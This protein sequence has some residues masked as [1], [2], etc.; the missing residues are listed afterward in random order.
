MRSE[1]DIRLRI[2]LLEGQASSIAK[3]LA[4]AMQEHNEEA[5]KNYSEKLA[6]RKG[7]VEELLWVLEVKM[8]QGVLD[9]KAAVPGMQE[10]VAVR[11]I[12]DL[13]KE[14]R[15]K[16]DDLAL[17]VQALVRKGALEARNAMRHTT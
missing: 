11:D 17:D 10:M 15:I 7:K 2:D 14:G 8:G 3:M 1:K 13:L 4:K 12:L 16:M 6:Q 5:I 9:T